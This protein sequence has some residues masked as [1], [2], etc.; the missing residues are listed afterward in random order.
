[1]TLET[2][3]LTLS[4]EEILTLVRDY[5][6]QAYGAPPLLREDAERFKRDLYVLIKRAV[7]DGK[8]SRGEFL[9]PI[10]QFARRSFRHVTWASFNWDCIFESS[11]YYSSGPNTLSRNNPTVVVKLKNWKHIATNHIF[12]KLHGGVN[13][14]FED[15]NLYYLPFGGQ[16]DLN[17]R[18]EEYQAGTARG[19]PVILEP[20]YYKYEDPVYAHLKEQWHY[21]VEALLEADV[22]IILGY[23]LPEADLEA[24]RALSIGF[25]SNQRAKFIIVNHADW[26][27]DRYKRIFGSHRATCLQT[28]VQGVSDQL[29]DLILGRH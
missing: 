18:W 12:L 15:D 8:S 26:V 11:F 13:W 25:Q 9:N 27:C 5:E 29:Q 24:R 17:E 1:M 20:S 3:H 23:S 22:V 14:W 28:N 21:F 2:S 7:Y 16:P 6:Y 4:V 10:L 19:M